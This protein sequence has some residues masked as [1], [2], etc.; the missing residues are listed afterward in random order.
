[1]T[2]IDDDFS[3]LAVFLKAQWLLAQGKHYPFADFIM[4]RYE[5]IGDSATGFTARV[6]WRAV[7]A[8]YQDANW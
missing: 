6:A 7:A 1:M 4:S 8:Q 3:P 2:P 5:C